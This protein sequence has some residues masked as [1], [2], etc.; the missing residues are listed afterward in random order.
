MFGCVVQLTCFIH[1]ITSEPSS[2][3]THGSFVIGF[4]S[5]LHI[6]WAQKRIR[7]FTAN[8]WLFAHRFLTYALVVV[9]VV[10]GGP[11]R[12]SPLYIAVS[13][14]FLVAYNGIGCVFEGVSQF[15]EF[16]IASLRIQVRLLRNVVVCDV[17]VW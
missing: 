12:V 2:F 8:V 15:S 5:E 13:F 16:H 14:M 4:R 17:T 1:D 6:I 11:L 9:C 7:A 10:S 3:V